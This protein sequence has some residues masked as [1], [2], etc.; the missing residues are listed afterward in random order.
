[1]FELGFSSRGAA[2]TAVIFGNKARYEQLVRS[3]HSDTAAG[4]SLYPEAEYLHAGVLGAVPLTA[5]SIYP[6]VLNHPT[7][8]QV[9]GADRTKLLT[10]LFDWAWTYWAIVGPDLVAPSDTLA[11]RF[12]QVTL[13]DAITRQWA[14][15]LEIDSTKLLYPLTVIGPLLNA[16]NASSRALSA[17]EVSQTMDYLQLLHELVMDGPSFAQSVVDGGVV[18]SKL[19]SEGVISGTSWTGSELLAGLSALSPSTA[20][21]ILG[22]VLLDV[23]A[24]E[25]LP[26]PQS[27]AG[28]LVHEL[29]ETSAGTLGL[30]G[31]QTLLGYATAPGLTALTSFEIGG[32]TALGA[33][34]SPDALAAILGTCFYEDIAL[35]EGYRLQEEVNIENTETKLLKQFEVDNSAMRYDT[36][37]SVSVA[38][39]ADLMEADRL[40][41]ALGAKWAA[42]DYAVTKNDPSCALEQAD[43]NGESADDKALSSRLSTAAQDL[44]SYTAKAT[45]VA[46]SIGSRGEPG[47]ARGTTRGKAPTSVASLVA[48]DSEVAKDDVA[49]GFC[50]PQNGKPR[51]HCNVPVQVAGTASTPDGVGGTLVAVKLTFPAASCVPGWP[52]WFFDNERIVTT[53]SSL[54]LPNPPGTNAWPEGVKVDGPG[55]FA[56]ETLVWGR[57]AGFCPAPPNHPH[58]VSYILAYRHGALTVAGS[59]STTGK[60]TGA[61]TT[62]T[63]AGT[64]FPIM[65]A[66]DSTFAPGW[67]GSG[68][69]CGWPAPGETVTPSSEQYYAYISGSGSWVRFSFRATADV[70]LRWLT[71]EGGSLN[72]G[73]AFVSVDGAHPVEAGTNALGGFYSTTSG[74]V[75][76]WKH[77]FSPGAHTIT[78]TADGADVNVYLVT[79]S[80]SVEVARASPQTNGSCG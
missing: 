55:R 8:P 4:G 29:A 40:I 68:A 79:S 6:G 70:T 65:D 20:A 77:S 2:F 49:E 13:A 80:P 26:K 22:G 64:V 58:S 53:S 75:V 16:A 69:S 74:P 39:A 59:T 9:Q 5:I 51:P 41:L 54:K 66:N 30:G 27:D 35:P 37:A 71:P 25:P 24:T 1:M 61:G 42:L 15:K 31:V 28:C 34:V 3:Q 67:T 43:C 62:S 36:T 23:Y 60:N 44:E 48:H 73:P 7:G 18:I 72:Q 63:T 78:W 11:E 12:A 21:G 76:L 38:T 10:E 17:G 19:Q 45:A 33:L 46:P 52:I 14:A 57:N 47:A 50:P 32:S 56:V